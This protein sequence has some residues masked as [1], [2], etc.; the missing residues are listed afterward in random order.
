VLFDLHHG[1]VLAGAAQHSWI[2][3]WAVR[4]LFLRSADRM[5]TSKCYAQGDSDL[6]RHII[7][8]A[9]KKPAIRKEIDCRSSHAHFVTRDKIVE[10]VVVFISYNKD[11]ATYRLEKI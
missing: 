3:S 10:S 5:M 1:A 11:N 2:A 8:R 6:P 7:P 9:S 4:R